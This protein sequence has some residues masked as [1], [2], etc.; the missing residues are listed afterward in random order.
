M[1]CWLQAL[2]LP[3][4]SGQIQGARL[5]TAGLY[6]AF[7]AIHILHLKGKGLN[8][9][10]PPFILFKALSLFHL[11]YLFHQLLSLPF[12]RKYL[13]FKPED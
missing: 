9:E 10:R 2:L 3:S 1:G 11:F 13:H 5:H 4:S 12:K 8:K 6:K 7:T